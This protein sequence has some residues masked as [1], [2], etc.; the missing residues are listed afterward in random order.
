MINRYLTRLALPL[1]I[2]FIVEYM[3]HVAATHNMWLQFFTLPM[4]LATPLMVWYILKQLRDRVMG[5]TIRGLEAWTFGTQL[6]F[7]AG[8]VEAMFIYLYNEYMS[9]NNLMEMQQALI[10]QYEEV[11]KV[12]NES[13]QGGS[14]PM[15]MSEAVEELKKA[16]I[17]SAIEAAI[18]QLS[19]TLFQGLMVMIPVGLVLRQK[20]K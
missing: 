18:N 5:G 4:M 14:L 9:P 2:W 19:T 3:V 16:P 20:N 15:F 17:P 8:L 10:A 1:A 7:Y 12:L 13:Q 11:S 6:F